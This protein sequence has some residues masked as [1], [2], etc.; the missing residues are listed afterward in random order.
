M[1]VCCVGFVLFFSTRDSSLNRLI[2]PE[3]GCSLDILIWISVGSLPRKNV[4]KL[5]LVNE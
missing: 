1:C 5:R 3:T 4:E 2:L